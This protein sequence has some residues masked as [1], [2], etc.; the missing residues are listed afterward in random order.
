[1]GDRYALRQRSYSPAPAPWRERRSRDRNDRY[2]P[3]PRREGRDRDSDGVRYEGKP[4]VGHHKVTIEGIP[5]DMSWMELKDLGTEYGKSLSF[6]RTYRQGNRYFGMLEYR[7]IDDAE[8][9]I[10]ELD[11]RRV[12][13]GSE[14]LRA[15]YGDLAAAGSLGKYR[16]RGEYE[17]TGDRGRGDS[18][19]DRD[20][21]R[22]RD[23]AYDR[24]RDRDRH[25]GGDVRDRSRGY[26][27]GADRRRDQDGDRRSRSPRRNNRRD[28]GEEMMTLFVKDLPSDSTEEEIKRDLDRSGKV[29]RVILMKRDMMA[30]FVRFETARDADRAMNDIADGMKVCDVR[31][32]AEMARRNT[33][34]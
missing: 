21:E 14:R 6:A 27:R 3:P 18:D 24:D 7:D 25:S 32:G 13:G 2:S 31:V 20:R 12:Q 28:D 29:L 9:A 10:R 16:G 19:R 22:D 26:D 17:G 5:N 4:P 30:A 33:S 15:T 8:R 34:V 23:R 1:M 11:K